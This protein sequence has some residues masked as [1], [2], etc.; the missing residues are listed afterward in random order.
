VIDL[1]ADPLLSRNSRYP[2]VPQPGSRSPLL[3]E[4]LLSG[5]HCRTPPPRWLRY[6][7]SEAGSLP[8]RARRRAHF[9]AVIS[10]RRLAINLLSRSRYRYAVNPSQLIVPR[11]LINSVVVKMSITTVNLILPKL[12]TEVLAMNSFLSILIEK[13]KKRTQ[14]ECRSLCLYQRPYLWKELT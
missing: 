12:E 7:L 3:Q 13:S 10:T 6:H 11:L 9:I 4:L 2:A 8:Y 1:S 14:T 5:I